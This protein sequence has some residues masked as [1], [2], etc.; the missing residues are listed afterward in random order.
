MVTTELAGQE[1]FI[2][3][4]LR[5]GSVVV[6]T[7]GR[8]LILDALGPLFRGKRKARTPVC[9]FL[10]KLKIQG[11]TKSGTLDDGAPH[12]PGVGSLG[13]L[14]SHNEAINFVLSD[15]LLKAG[16]IRSQGTAFVAL[17]TESAL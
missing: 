4:N 13:E 5:G 1:I 11:W 7:Q 14:N 12:G 17:K 6:Y 16:I 15:A 8:E 9:R 2:I 3:R 10:R